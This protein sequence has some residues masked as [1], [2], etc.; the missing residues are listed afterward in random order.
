MTN[1][2]APK[3]DIESLDEEPTFGEMV[4]ARSE[5]L[6][7]QQGK[8]GEVDGKEQLVYEWKTGFSH[9]KRFTLSRPVLPTI[10]PNTVY[11]LKFE[12]IDRRNGNGGHC[13]F[14]Q[15]TGILYDSTEG[16]VDRSYDELT[17]RGKGL[18]VPELHQWTVLDMLA[19]EAQKDTGF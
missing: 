4:V 18:T 12:E 16:L 15:A 8:T 2:E 11:R 3:P 19:S 6:L 14:T 7:L 10:G 5:R 17:A 9:H 1:P 13:D